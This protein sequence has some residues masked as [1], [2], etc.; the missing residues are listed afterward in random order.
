MWAITVSDID[1]YGRRS[2]NGVYN[3][4]WKLHGMVPWLDYTNQEE[5]WIEA[6]CFDPMVYRDRNKDLSSDLTDA[7]L[8]QHWLEHGIKEGRPSSTVLDLGFYLSNNP[9]LQTAFG[10]DHE[11]LYEHFVTSGY[12]EYRK[13]SALFD[14]SFY[15]KNHPDV[16]SAFGDEYLRHYVQNGQAEGRRASLTF[17]PDHYWHI[18]PDVYE[19]WPNDYTMCARHYAGHGINAQIEAYDHEHPVISD[20]TISDVTAAGYTVT[21]KAT[22]DWG[23]SKVVF[24]TWTVQNGQDDLAENFMNTQTGTKNGDTYTFQVKA[25]DHNN[26]GGHYLTH[27]Y[28]VDKG[29]N[30]TQ[31]VLE[32]VAVEDPVK[33]TE[34][35]LSGSASYTS[36][37]TLLQGVTADT[38]VQS[39]LTQFDNEVLEVL[40]ADGN[41]I[42]GAAL[43]GTG[44][45]VNLYDGAQLLDPVTVVVLGDVDGNGAVNTTDYARIR[46]LFQ[47]TFVMDEAQTCAADVDRNGVIDSTD[48]LRIKAYFLENFQ[49]YA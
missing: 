10:T 21:C 3:G 8:K 42:T 13:S 33:E 27:I 2:R 36:D 15:T 23:I 6:A 48:H 12:K 38:S 29:G 39:L 1:K 28:A 32:T 11:K 22:D 25:S 43:V 20:V 47:N 40:D 45:T 37:G 26:E 46:S 41:T 44:A 35:L 19:A 17:D 4:Y 49:L 14:G 7:Q 5:T 16:D 31:M 30:Q 9:D 34:I 18:R 24:P